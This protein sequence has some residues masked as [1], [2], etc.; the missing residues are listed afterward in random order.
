MQHCRTKT[1]SL[2]GRGDKS[3]TRYERRE[4]TGNSNTGNSK[5]KVVKFYGVNIDS[6]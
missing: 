3:E 6:E 2:R 5:T 1:N 4:N